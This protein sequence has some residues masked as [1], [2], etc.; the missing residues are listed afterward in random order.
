MSKASRRRQQPPA[1]DPDRRAPRPPARPGDRRR[2]RVVDR[3][4]RVVGV[5]DARRASGHHVA[6]PAASR[7]AQPRARPG[8]PDRSPHPRDLPHQQRRSP[9]GY[10]GRSSDRRPGGRGADRR[11]LLLLGVARRPMPARPSSSRA[12]R[13]APAR[14]DARSRATSQDD[15]GRSTSP[16]GEVTYT[17][18]PPASG[19]HY[20]AA[21]L[22]PILPR[23]LRRRT[24]RPS[25]RAGSTTSSTARLVLLYRGDSEGATPEGQQAAQGLLRGLPA[26]PGLQHRPGHGGDRSSR[27]STR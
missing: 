16:P 24:T 18:C 25:R 19:N 22:G 20:N 26:E 17:Y 1:P 7:P 13:H 9:S 3:R 8:R 12:D 6:R 21:G 14:A 4:D 27:A 23:V 5:V 10:R 15:M 2:R 11:V